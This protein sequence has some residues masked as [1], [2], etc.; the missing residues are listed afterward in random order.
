VAIDETTASSVTRR[1]GARC[2]YCL[3]PE[4]ASE[5]RH[6]IDHVIAVQHGGGDDP[7]N[8]AFACVRCNRHKGPNLSG[9][10]PHTGLLTPLYNPRSQRWRSHFRYD[11]QGLLHGETAA[12]RVTVYVLAINLPLRIAVRRSLMAEGVEFMLPE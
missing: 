5:L 1:A 4:A 6:V 8:L 11:E 2:E 7:E 9:I 12:G 10:D 3:L